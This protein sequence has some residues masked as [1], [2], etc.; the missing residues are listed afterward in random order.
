M[1]AFQERFQRTGV[2][3]RLNNS[4]GPSSR[5]RT[6]KISSSLFDQ[7]GICRSRELFMLDIPVDVNNIEIWLL[8]I[9]RQQGWKSLEEALHHLQI[10]AGRRLI[11][12][13]ENIATTCKL[14][15]IGILKSAIILSKCNKSFYI[16]GS[17]MIFTRSRLE[18]KIEMLMINIEGYYEMD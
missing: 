6:E 9:A 10:P 15:K 5:V 3:S 8:S 2:T 18:R 13:V 16:P 14:S 11:F 12:P 4:G 7:P 1:R 17:P